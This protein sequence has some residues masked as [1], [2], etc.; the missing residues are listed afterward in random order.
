MP[1]SLIFKYPKA[2]LFLSQH[3]EMT[4]DQAIDF[5]QNQLEEKVGNEISL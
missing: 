4:I 2:S 3:P 1:S 5:L